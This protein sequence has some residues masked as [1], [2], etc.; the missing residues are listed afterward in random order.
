MT[1][2]TEHAYE[3]AGGVVGVSATGAVG[4]YLLWLWRDRG[5]GRVAAAHPQL[6]D[7]HG[8]SFQWLDAAGVHV[9]N[10]DLPRRD[11][12]EDALLTLADID[13]NGEPC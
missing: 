8:K 1:W 5:R 9:V 2:I 3:L 11:Q 13:P 10:A 7:P 12:C 4:A 6:I